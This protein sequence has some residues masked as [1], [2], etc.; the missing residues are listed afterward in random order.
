MG[1]YEVCRSRYRVQKMKAAR[2]RMEVT[3]RA[4]TSILVSSP[5]DVRQPGG[6]QMNGETVWC[7]WQHHERER[8]VSD[9]GV[10]HLGLPGDADAPGRGSHLH[11]VRHPS[12]A[13]PEADRLNVNRHTAAVN[14]SPPT[15]STRLSGLVTPSAANGR[16]RSLGVK[17]QPMT[18]IRSAM[19]M[20]RKKTYGQFPLFCQ[21]SAA[22][23]RALSPCTF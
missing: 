20:R 19:P 15:Q 6:R 8:A 17:N 5:L 4:G 14:S 12:G 9:W 16:L 22:R 1:G 3:S 13:D 10:C 21:S 2:R 11:G 7:P 18:A 23:V